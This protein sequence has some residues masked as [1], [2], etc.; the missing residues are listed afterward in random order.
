LLEV[1]RQV[2]KHRVRQ[3]NI[4]GLRFDGGEIAANRLHAIG[5]AVQFRTPAR[6]VDKPGVHIH[7][8][9]A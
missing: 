8:D 7:G 1:V 3:Y 4:Y 2:M 9:H 6:H 5:D